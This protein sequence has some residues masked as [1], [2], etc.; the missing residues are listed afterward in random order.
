M[1]KLFPWRILR[2]CLSLDCRHSFLENNL[3]FTPVETIGIK[4]PEYNV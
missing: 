2:D 3:K 4:Q 1:P